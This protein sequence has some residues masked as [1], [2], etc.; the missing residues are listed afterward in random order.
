MLACAL[1]E[2]LL[3]CDRPEEALAR[4][5]CGRN[6]PEEYSLGRQWVRITH[7][8]GECHSACGNQEVATGYFQGS[9]ADARAIPSV[10][11]ECKCLV[12]FGN[13]ENRWGNDERARELYAEGR[14]LARESDIPAFQDLFCNRME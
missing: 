7:V 2:T 8:I 1:A 6:R 11:H 5:K 10:G 14:N 13:A 12:A 3:A 9:L 4:A